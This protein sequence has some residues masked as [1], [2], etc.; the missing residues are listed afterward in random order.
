MRRKGKAPGKKKEG[1]V[2]DK[3]IKFIM[4]ND[5]MMGFKFEKLLL[6]TVYG[7]GRKY[8]LNGRCFSKKG[9]V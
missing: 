9:A 4:V 6:A 1:G 2:A 3:N 7:T 5:I 8:K